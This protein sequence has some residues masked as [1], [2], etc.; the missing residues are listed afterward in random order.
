M[1]KQICLV[2][3]IPMAHQLSLNADTDG[4]STLPKSS[5]SIKEELMQ[6]KGLL[7]KK[8][9][10]PTVPR[11]KVS[12]IMPNPQQRKESQASP[13]FANQAQSQVKLMV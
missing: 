7:L 2:A 1:P 4:T 5:L 13:N 8:A 11:K 3:A 9:I 10:D 6:K 12:L